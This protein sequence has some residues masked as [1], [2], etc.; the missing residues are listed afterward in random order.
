MN[1]YVSGMVNKYGV[2]IMIVVL[3]VCGMIISNKFLSL[4]NILN[5][6]EAVTLLGMVAGG[7][8]LVTYREFYSIIE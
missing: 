4:N 1:R 5:V 3:V 2:Y 6:V 7:M 8:A